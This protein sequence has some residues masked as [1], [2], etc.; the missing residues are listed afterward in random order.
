ML[1]YCDLG[2]PYAEILG[3]SGRSL[4]SCWSAAASTC[5]RILLLA[6]HEPQSSLFKGLPA[7]GSCPSSINCPHLTLFNTHISSASFVWL[8]PFVDMI[9][10]TVPTDTSVWTFQWTGFTLDLDFCTNLELTLL[11]EKGTMWHKVSSFAWSLND[12]GWLSWK[13]A[14]LKKPQNKHH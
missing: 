1:Q 6:A 12:T 3:V 13:P 2:V 8:V 10:F 14:L 11:S 9:W 5:E 4:V 7:Q